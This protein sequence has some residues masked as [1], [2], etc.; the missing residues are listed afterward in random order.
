MKLFTDK[1]V[2]PHGAIPNAG[3]IVTDASE[4]VSDPLPWQ[5]RGLSQTATGYGRRLTSQYKINFNN[6]L[7]R[8]YVT[9]LGNA[10]S[11]WFKVKGKTIFIS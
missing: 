4:L 8:L 3:R 11:T 2:A 5:K 6:K 1:D 7:R 10:G 9:C